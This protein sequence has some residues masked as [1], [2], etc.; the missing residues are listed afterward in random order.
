[1]ANLR[2]DD[3]RFRQLV[4]DLDGRQADIATALG[5]TV[6]AVS[7]RLRRAKHRQ[8]WRRLKENRSKRKARERQER[9]RAG[10]NARSQPP[11]DPYGELL[12]LCLQ[13]L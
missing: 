1:M 11:A 5:I 10:V 7:R 9:W 2:D 4:V 13:Y 3:L 6:G 12:M 8:F